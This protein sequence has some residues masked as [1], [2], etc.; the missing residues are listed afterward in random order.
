MPTIC[1]SIPTG[2]GN[3]L[4][5]CTVR[6]RISPR[7]PYPPVAQWT[8][9]GRFYRTGWGF[10]SS[11]GVQLTYTT[12]KYYEADKQYYINK[13]KE[14][15]Q[16]LRKMVDEYKSVPCMDCGIQY[17]PHVMDFD[18]RENKFDDV[19]RLVINNVSVKR[20][21]DEIAKCDV[22]C[23]NCHRVR[24]YERRATNVSGK[25]W[26]KSSTDLS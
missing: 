24:T 6:V 11:Q 5:N 26:E 18:H 2:R 7:T 17:P 23:S 15:K 1:P 14:R 16:R 12:K 21:L 3:S 8:R 25:G 9:A 22:V 4:R 19:A 10:E 20:I 13:A